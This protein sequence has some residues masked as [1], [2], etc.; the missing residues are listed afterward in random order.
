MSHRGFL[1]PLISPRHN[2]QRPPPAPTPTLNSIPEA[3]Q[4][5]FPRGVGRPPTAVTPYRKQ[6]YPGPGGALN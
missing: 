5:L 6:A 4:D 1:S 2:L 3:C